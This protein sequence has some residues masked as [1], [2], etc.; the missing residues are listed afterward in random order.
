MV[1]DRRGNWAKPTLWTSEST[2]NRL[3]ADTGHTLAG[4]RQADE[5]LGVDEIFELPTDGVVSMK[6]EASAREKAPVRHVLE[7]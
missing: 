2:A 3:L 1:A 4:L 7:A 5:N 6:A